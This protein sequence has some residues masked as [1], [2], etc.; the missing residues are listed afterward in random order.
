[1]GSQH[2][3]LGG[4]NSVPPKATE[5]IKVLYKGAHYPLDLFIIYEEAGWIPKGTHTTLQIVTESHQTP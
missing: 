3:V 5:G 4:A 2:E 1:M